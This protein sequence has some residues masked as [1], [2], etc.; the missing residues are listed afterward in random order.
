M[1]STRFGY[2]DFTLFYKPRVPLF[3]VLRQYPSLFLPELR[4]CTNMG[5]YKKNEAAYEKEK[6]TEID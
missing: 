4:V 3:F 6:S 2:I 5:L 1:T